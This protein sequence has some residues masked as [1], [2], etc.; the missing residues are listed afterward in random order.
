MRVF[1]LGATGQIGTAVS[2]E[3]KRRGHSV[4]ALARSAQSAEKAARLGAEPLAGNIMEPGK[5]VSALPPVDAVIHAAQDLECPMA[6]VDRH[7]LDALLA[8][9]GRRSPKIRFVYTGGNWLF[10]PTDGAV[11]D[12]DSPF[13]PPPPLRGWWRD[14]RESLEAMRSTAS[15]FIR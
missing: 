6:E 15:S 8:H 2:V 13:A 10:G 11:A 3:L 4:L 7:L 1:V 9:L 5:W 14:C 12:E